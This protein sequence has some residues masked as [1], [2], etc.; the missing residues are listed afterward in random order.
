MQS[1]SSVAGMVESERTMSCTAWMGQGG[2]VH[3]C[4][5]SEPHPGHQHY[6]HKAGAT[7]TGETPPSA[8]L[9]ALPWRTGRRVGRTIYAQP[10]A[11]PSDHDPL[12]GV[13][14]TPQL[15]SAAVRA[16]NEPATLHREGQ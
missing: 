4:D 15:A 6:N 16:H 7:W 14:D 2:V 5:W 13:M 12:I 9:V 10:G 1:V 8:D 11:E 3:H